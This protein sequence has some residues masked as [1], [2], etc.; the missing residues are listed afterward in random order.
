MTQVLRPRHDSEVK[1]ESHVAVFERSRAGRIHGCRILYH[2]VA[3]FVKRTWLMLHLLVLF[4]K[5]VLPELLIL[6]VESNLTLRSR[7]WCS[8]SIGERLCSTDDKM[9]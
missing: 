9:C 6:D 3:K 8:I 1:L 4:R 5:E 7:F 2:Y